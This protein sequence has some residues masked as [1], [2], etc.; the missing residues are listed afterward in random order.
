MKSSP[1]QSAKPLSAFGRIRANYIDAVVRAFDAGAAAQKIAVRPEPGPGPTTFVGFGMTSVPGNATANIHV[2]P[3]VTFAPTGLLIPRE[4][5]KKFTIIDIKIGK[6]SQLANSGEIPATAFSTTAWPFKIR[7]CHVAQ[8]I[9]ISV[10]NRSKDDAI[11]EAV[12][13]GHELPETSH[14]TLV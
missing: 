8:D 11:F 12:I 9:I 13:V 3:Q 4:V 10:R 1:S 14:T 6:N 7:K 5:A 2:R